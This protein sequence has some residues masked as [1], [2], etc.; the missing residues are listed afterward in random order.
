[1]MYTLMHSLNL[2]RALFCHGFTTEH[3]VSVLLAYFDCVMCSRDIIRDH[4]LK[5]GLPSFKWMIRKLREESSAIRH[6][7]EF[8]MCITLFFTC[9]FIL[10]TPEVVPIR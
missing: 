2:S 3:F 5:L 6:A 9:G 7:C 1:M 10:K 8:Q 4:G